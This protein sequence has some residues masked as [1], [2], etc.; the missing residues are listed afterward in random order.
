MLLFW[1]VRWINVPKKQKRLKLV[2]KKFTVHIVCLLETHVQISNSTPVADYILPG[3]SFLANYEF[4]SREV[5]IFFDSSIRM[6][7]FHMSA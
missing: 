2:L 5:W 1:N 7:I 3:W 6:D 4:A